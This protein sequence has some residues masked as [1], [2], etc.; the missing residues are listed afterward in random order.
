MPESTGSQSNEELQSALREIRARL[1]KLEEAVYELRGGEEPAG[2][3]PARRTPVPPPPPRA[4]A[5]LSIEPAKALDPQAMAQATTAPPVRTSTFPP[6]PLPAPKPAGPSFEQR[7]G[8]RWMLIIG[9][10]VLLLAAVFFFKYASDKGWIQPWLHLAAAALGGLVMIGLGEWAIRR[11]LRA[12]AAGIIGGGIIVLYLSAYVASPNGLPLYRNLLGTPVA[13]GLMCLVTLLGAAMSLRTGLLLAAMLT[14]VGAMASPVLLSTGENRLVFLMCYLLVVDAGFLTVAML[15]RW[16]LLAPVA[17]IGT[18]FLFSGWH[19]Q[20]YT[21]ESV[22]RMFGFAWVLFAEF[23]IYAGA[24]TAAG[25]ARQET[26][27]VLLAGAGGLTALLT[28]LSSRDLTPS[29]ILGQ[30]TAL[31]VA[32]LAMSQWRR[33]HWVRMGV[34]GWTVLGLALSLDGK[35]P[36]AW[37]TCWWI[38]ALFAIFTADILIRAWRRAAPAVET[39]DAALAALAG[40]AMFG[41]TYGLLHADYHRWMGLYAVGLGVAMILLAWPVRRSAGRRTLAYSYLGQG[42]VLITLAVPIQ[43][44]WSTVTIA[45]AIQGVVT[46]FLARRLG[47]RLLMVKSPVV[48]G[49]ALLHFVYREVPGDPRMAET[50]ATVYGIDFTFRLLLALGLA[51][52][53]MLAATI[54]RVGRRADL[55]AGVPLA[56]ALVAAGALVCVYSTAFWLPAL[57]ATWWWVA[58]AAGIGAVAGW[59]RSAWLAWVGMGLVLASAGKW[60][61]YDTL[62]LRVWDALPDRAIAFNWQAGC[63]LA[64]VMALLVW[65]RFLAAPRT[66][67]ALANIVA[68]T[69]VLWAGSFEADRYF[70]SPGRTWPDRFQ[71]MH[72]SYSLWWA[73]CA[74]GALILGFV[75]RLPSLRYFAIVV[76]AVALA[77]LFLVDM[78]GIEAVYR[79]LSFLGLGLLL[80]AGSLLY[81]RYFRC[82]PA[83]GGRQ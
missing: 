35:H 1:A 57:T 52:A 32:A 83:A 50:L 46:M 26:G 13:F 47:S 65:R 33:W 24:G 6:S 68:A 42:L 53:A 11:N 49:L 58:L 79:I 20:H 76:F 54:L 78:R 28:V 61:V 60:L 39:L 3:P 21:A 69:A 36:T 15:K 5:V 67:W 2:M 27:I 75:R 31:A 34:L 48:L 7:I 30:F 38:W 66:F 55:E 19:A 10:V 40:A 51:A 72:M 43:W 62:A 56:V 14:L 81:H 63:G 41:F 37:P 9:V 16:E 25:R 45:W 80:V 44:D 17:M 4:P 29:V 77:K 82:A 64:V 23:M 73:A 12:F 8:T 70:S 71:A 59:R 22:S 74:A 18:V